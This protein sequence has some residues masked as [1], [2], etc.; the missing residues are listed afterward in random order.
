MPSPAWVPGLQRAK[1]H[2][3]PV[4]SIASTSGERT[5]MGVGSPFKNGMSN[6][7]QSKTKRPPKA[8][9]MGDELPKHVAV[10]MDGSHRWAARRG[11]PGFAGHQAGVSTFM[12]ILSLCE[13]TGIKALTVYAFSWENW[14]RPQKEVE[15]IL[16]LIDTTVA[17]E[18]ERWNARGTRFVVA[19]SREKLPDSL[20]RRIEWAE[21]LTEDNTGLVVTVALSYG[22]RQDIAAAARKIAELAAKGL[23]DPSEVDEQMIERH[24]STAPVLA[25]VGPP[26][27]LIRTSGEKRL[28]NF[29]LYEMAYTEIHFTTT[30]WPDFGEENFSLALEDFASRK[31]TYGARHSHRI[32]SMP[33]DVAADEVGG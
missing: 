11:L 19:G 28:S 8:V 26:D 15:Y 24:L 30:C 25:A 21:K 22:G 13:S 31:R 14:Q 4:T 16:Q 1:L 12:R 9:P 32:G 23:I 27:L 20:R 6:L 17:E 29:L 3:A 33:G 5:H 18:A 7:F 2:V 10:V